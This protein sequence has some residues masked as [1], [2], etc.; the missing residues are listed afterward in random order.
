[1]DFFQAH[2]TISTMDWVLRAAVAFFIM[3]ITVRI[4]GLRTISQLRAIDFVIAFMLGNI[5]AHPLSDQTIGMKGSIISTIVLAFL[6]IGGVFLT[7]KW[8]GLRKVLDSEPVP[9]INK[10]EISYNALKKTRISIDYLLSEL[11]KEKVEDVRKVALALWETDGTISIFLDPK[12]QPLTPETYQVM[13]EPFELPRVIISDGKINYHELDQIKMEE[14]SLIKSLKESHQT[15]VNQVLL[16][17]I[18]NKNNLQVF[19]YK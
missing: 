19:L 12:Y 17:T 16:A 11:R 3:L 14:S 8:R 2:E 5:I 10:G 15:V 7:Q 9:L 18:D 1:M 4:M 6:Y 13:P